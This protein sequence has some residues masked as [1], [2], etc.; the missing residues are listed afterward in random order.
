MHIEAIRKDYNNTT[1]TLSKDEVKYI[2]AGLHKELA[3]REERGKPVRNFKIF[4]AHMLAIENL[5]HEGIIYDTTANFMH[6]AYESEI[7]VFN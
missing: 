6:E 4:A 3:E 5:L 2:V 1:V 7:D